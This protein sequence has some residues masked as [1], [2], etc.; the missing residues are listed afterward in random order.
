M[1]WKPGR[2]YQ[3]GQPIFPVIKAWIAA[4][5]YQKAIAIMVP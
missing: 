5:V 3:P 1:G 4:D 2:G